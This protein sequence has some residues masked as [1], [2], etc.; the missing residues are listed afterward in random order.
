MAT[1]LVNLTFDPVDDRV[2]G[3][4]SQSR[5]E[6]HEGQIHYTGVLSRDSGGGFVSM[7]SRPAEL[8]LDDAIA[9]T[10]EVRGDGRTYA[11]TMQR[12]DVR[13][14]AGSYRAR[15]VATDTWTT[16]EL[17]LADFTAMSR[18]RDVPGA[19]ALDAAPDRIVS[20]GVL[21]TDG[22]EGIFT[23]DIRGLDVVRGAVGR[24]PGIDDVTSRLRSALAQGVPAFNAGRPDLCRDAYREALIALQDHAALTPGERK[25]VA[26]ALTNA[27]GA[28]PTEGAWAL[29]FAIDTVLASI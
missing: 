13:M 15:F 9:V 5:V 6:S 24:G 1:E 17:P 3:G 7:R 2:M 27:E 16:V 23:L 12:S 29:R 22:P 26:T 18:G 8:P 14:P 20:V 28:P 11:F 19:P 21:L 25:I 10:M 4:V